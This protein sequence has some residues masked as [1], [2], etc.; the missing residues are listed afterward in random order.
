MIYALIVV[1]AVVVITLAVLNAWQAT[2]H[3]EILTDL[4]R[5]QAAERLRWANERKELFE[6]MKFL[7][8]RYLARHAQDAVMMDR[9]PAEAIPREPREHRNLMPEGL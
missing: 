7:N 4:N 9:F 3:R 1:F 5:E 2:I 6:Q 8:D